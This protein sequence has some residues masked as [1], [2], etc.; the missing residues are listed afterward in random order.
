MSKDTEEASN[1]E[2]E[3][4]E[5]PE[6][7]RKF[8]LVN[9][10]QEEKEAFEDILINT[11]NVLIPSF[12][13]DGMKFENQNDDWADPISTDENAI[14]VELLMTDTDQTYIDRVEISVSHIRRLR[15]LQ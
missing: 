9:M 12:E 14:M 5:A 11:I 15:E 10:T 7:R 1:V 4:T 2:A 6:P 13:H 8:K 3:G